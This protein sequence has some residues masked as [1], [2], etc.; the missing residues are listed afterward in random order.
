ML[1]PYNGNIS[2]IICLFAHVGKDEDEGSR[3]Y[4]IAAQPLSPKGGGEPFSSPVRYKKTTERDYRLSGVSRDTLQGAPTFADVAAFLFPLFRETNI[5]VTLNPREEIESLLA[6]Y[7]NPRV[8]DL[9]FAAEF[10]LPHANTASPKSLWEYLH[11]KKREKFS[12]SA[13]EALLLSVELLKHL[14]GFILNPAEFPPAAALRFY[15]RKSETLFGDLFIGLN[16]NF[17]DY[18]GEL[19]NPG[20]GEETDDWKGFLEKAPL[21]IPVPVP[22]ERR[23]KVSL[24]HIEEIYRALSAKTKNYVIRPPQIAYAKHVATALNERE[25]LTIEAGTGTGKTQGYLIPAMEFLAKNPG[26]RIAISTYTKNLQEQLVRR[27]LPLAASLKPAYK[28]IPVAMLKGKSNYLCAEKLDHIYEEALSGSRLLLWLYFV[29]KIFYFRQVDGET[30]GERIRFH[31]NDGFFF[32]RLQHEISARSGCSRRHSRCPAQVIAAEALNARLV[33]TNHH[34]L[35]L[36]NK[37]GA[38][39]GIFGNCVI[40]E[41]NHFEQAARS[42]F[43]ME[44]SSREISDSAT[45]IETGL[46]RIP[47]SQG[48]SCG[49]AAGE[50]LDAINVLREEMSAFSSVISSIRGAPSGGKATIIPAEHP[51]FRKGRLNCQL[52]D[53]R[54]VLKKIAVCLS[55]LKDDESCRQL[56]IRPR[57]LERL[58][59]AL[60]DIEEYGDTIKAI[61]DACDSPEYVTAA[62]LYVHHWSVSTQ[63]VEVADILRTHLYKI[64]DSVIFTSATLRQNESFAGFMSIAGMTP[65]NAPSSETNQEDPSSA[66][67]RSVLQQELTK[68]KTDARQTKVHVDNIA[69]AGEHIKSCHAGLDPASSPVP[70]YENKASLARLRENEGLDIHCCRSNNKQERDF[71]FEAIPSPFA[72]DAFVIS[73]PP[74]A[75]SGAYESKEFW[76]SR[77]AEL[78]PG[79]I[80]ENRGRTLVLFASYGDLKEIAARI[81]DDIRASGY[82]L[83]LQESGASTL[84]LVDE[85][86]EIRESVLFG[87]DS[88]WFGVDFPGD[89][90]TQVIITRLPFPHPQ[91]PLQIARRNILAEKEY[92]RRYRYETAIKLRQGIGRLIRSEAD[93]GQ[94]VILDARY[95]KYYGKR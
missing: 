24:P 3:I 26:A 19:F 45:Y 90:L 2:N 54:K 74:E 36:L 21:K 75:L 27:E 47:P 71:R 42:A 14:S 30:T 40:D 51:S 73:V 63:A 57:T 5:V 10:F 33:I 31:L 77:V 35:A 85:F 37:D 66:G 65:K 53:L 12:F 25:V 17:Q 39:A 82:P 8:V 15:L 11:G 81:G 7:G 9:R 61:A 69:P 41:A 89:T 94:V 86:R 55:F 13:E 46:R 44:V 52:L 80:H 68:N 88:F 67:K 59:T 38:L 58:R 16:S 29:N 62:V 23:K 50:A 6:V 72:P 76:L 32:R 87:V 22:E 83:L 28:K 91:D 56:G 70:D 18:F 1:L 78:L 34:K 92:W 20:G 84:A 60:Q 79:L 64:W 93:S 95:R 43:A 4:Q 49:K 48:D